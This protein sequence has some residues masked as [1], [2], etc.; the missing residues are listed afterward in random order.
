MCS[1]EPVNK[2]VV[3]YPF[4]Q[5]KSVPMVYNNTWGP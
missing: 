2:L 1:E 5:S 3:N 4:E